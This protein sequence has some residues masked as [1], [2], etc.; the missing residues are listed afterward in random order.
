MNHNRIDNPNAI[1]KSERSTNDGNS[2]IN[3]NHGKSGS[4]L[5]GS[6]YIKRPM[7]SGIMGQAN[8]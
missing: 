5:G 7:G 6:E 1:G 4:G 2:V 8:A 3:C